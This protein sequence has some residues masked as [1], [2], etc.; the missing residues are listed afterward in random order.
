MTIDLFV[1]ILW[2]ISGILTI[3]QGLS[4]NNY[5]VPLGSY[6]LCWFV[7]ILYLIEKVS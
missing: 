3:I 7:L 6:L 5:K 1:L 4:D 2:I